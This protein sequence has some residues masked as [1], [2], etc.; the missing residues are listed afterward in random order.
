MKEKR[1]TRLRDRA[2]APHRLF[3]Y[4]YEHERE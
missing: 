3:E 4:D 2:P 1:S